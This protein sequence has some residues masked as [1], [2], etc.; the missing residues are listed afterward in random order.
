MENYPNGSTSLLTGANGSGKS[1]LVD[2][3]LTLIVPPSR[4]GFNLASGAEGRK[5]G[6]RTVDLY[7]H[8]EYGHTRDEENNN[9]DQLLRLRGDNSYSVLCALFVNA[10]GRP[11]TL[12]QLVYAGNDG[13]AE[14]I[15]IVAEDVLEIQTH[16]TFN[17][18]VRGFQRRLQE[19]GCRVYD[20]FS[21][22]SADFK[23]L[24]GLRSDNALVLFNKIVS[25]KEMGP[26]NEF[27]RESMLD[28]L[29]VRE[30]IENLYKNYQNLNDLYRVIQRDERA[31]QQLNPLADA[32]AKAERTRHDLEEANR[33]M[34]IVPAY[35]A[36]R[37]GVLLDA[38][39]QDV[40]THLGSLRIE[41]DS[42]KMQRESKQ[43]EAESLRFSIQTD[44]VGSQ[45][46]ALKKDIDS[47]KALM[48]PK[49]QRANAYN[50]IAVRVGLPSYTDAL[51]FQTNSD[52]VQRHLSE[53]AD[54]EAVLDRNL[55]DQYR[56]AD[57]SQTLCSEYEQTLNA[58]RTAKNKLDW[59]LTDL[60]DRL[61]AALN[62]ESAELPFV[63][64]LLQV[65]E[66]QHEWEA[67]IEK[68]LH[69][70]AQRLLVTPALY[71][72]VRQYIEQTTL[73]NQ[74][75]YNV[76]YKP[77]QKAERP[78]ER[79][80]ILYK[81]DIK[82][83][84]DQQFIDWLANDLVQTWS[85]ACVPD[86]RDFAAQTRAI[87][88]RGQ[89]K[90]SE[91][92]HEKDDR[93]FGKADTYVLGWN[94]QA[95]IAALEAQLREAQA[96]L[97]AARRLIDKLENERR[98]FREQQNDLRDMA[99]FTTFE[100][101]DWR[102]D[103]AQIDTS[104]RRSSHI[105]VQFRPT[106]DLAKSTECCSDRLESAGFANSADYRRNRRFRE[107]TGPLS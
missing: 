42:A 79:T 83:D 5:R 22:Y 88:A 66:D 93:Q 26:L 73:N 70:Y 94:N 38:E 100:E 6:E 1:T 59:H 99:A 29:N 97:A 84:T 78:T 65:R 15:Y 52:T 36:Y 49:N 12:A 61:T 37:K 105:G 27:V 30:R 32:S 103:Q 80:L 75:V 57:D 89:I 68:L 107:Q 92:R 21:K 11:I 96:Q 85:Y 25:M 43:I 35:M 46:Q 40:E 16:L 67:A 3:L 18:D 4:R 87:T 90:H 47:R 7:F 81:L 58:M 50:A 60:R 10:A 33:C 104:G 55:R 86:V 77:R 14:P 76:V 31:L 13:K 72:A 71:D 82:E 34:V 51:K 17:G 53:L 64:E 98:Q 106:S 8:G 62:L 91:S 101:I 9:R 20:E 41:L 54:S 74:I 102:P 56:L 23:R 48:R 24:F 44:R 95:K 2:A 45:I 39:I 28:P 19:Q 63:G 69:G